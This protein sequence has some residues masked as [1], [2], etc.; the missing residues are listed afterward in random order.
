MSFR[1]LY[2]ENNVYSLNNSKTKMLLIFQ[3][4]EYS[5]NMKLSIMNH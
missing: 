3:F 5:Y 2:S 4:Y 1:V